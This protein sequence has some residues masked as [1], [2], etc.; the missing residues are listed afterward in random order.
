MVLAQAKEDMKRNPRLTLPEDPNKHLELLLYN[1]SDSYYHE[2]LSFG[3]FDYTPGRSVSGDEF[4]QGSQYA[5]FTPRI[6]C[7]I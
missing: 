1:E 2:K 7:T 3:H 5:G 4:V 6:T